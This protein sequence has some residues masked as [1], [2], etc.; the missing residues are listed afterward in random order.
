[1]FI[2]KYII[3]SFLISWL[4]IR[5]F[6]KKYDLFSIT[7]FLAP[8]S[9]IYMNIGLNLSIF[10]VF[11]ILLI[12]YM[13]LL[14]IYNHKISFISYRNINLTIFIF[15]SIIV[16]IILSIYF[17]EDFKNMGGWFRSEGRFFSQIILFLLSFSLI[18]IAFHYI[19]SIND[20]F[21]YIKVILEG[22]IILAVLGWLQFFIFNIFHIDI[23][24]LGL[25]DGIAYS[26]IEQ[27]LNLFRISSLS[28]EPKGLSI[29]MVIAFFVLQVFNHYK[30]QF[31]KYDSLIKLLFFV[32]CFATLATSGIVLFF[33]IGF[34]YLI[35][36]NRKLLK[37][38][39]KNFFLFFIIICIFVSLGYVYYEILKSLIESRLL[40]RDIVSE[41]FDAPIQLF[42]IDKKEYL[43]FGVGL[44]NIHN[45][46]TNY[47]PFEYLH[48][49]NKIIFSAKSGYLKLIS[50]IGI[51]GFS[52]FII[53]FYKLY[54][55][56]KIVKHYYSNENQRL[57]SS[58]QLILLIVLIGYLSRN[59]LFN[60]LIVFLAITNV[61]SNLKIRENHYEN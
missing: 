36:I 28:H 10:Q 9:A 43:F 30:I 42:L 38:S 16:T 17:I 14:M 25:R 6:R 34:V 51:V 21:K 50:E 33:I 24:P 60:E 48:Y 4:M 57:I 13:F 46:V 7:I 12:L 20:V 26:G 61:V 23:F 53:I 44:G 59:Y 39:F 27:K 35:F 32:T 58:L 49:M 2:Y 22:M 8:F 15:Y 55:N 5:V 19:K 41:D 18:S 52:L 40:D 45:L 1:M 54:K 56:L 29:F 11:Q 47:I 3:V 31:F 37:N